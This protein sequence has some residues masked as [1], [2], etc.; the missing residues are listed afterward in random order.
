M[1]S[2][3]Y[4]VQ[5]WEEEVEEDI[6]NEFSDNEFEHGGRESM[7][8]APRASVSSQGSRRDNERA[9]TAINRGTEK[10]FEEQ[11]FKSADVMSRSPQGSPVQ[12]SSLEED[13]VEERV[14]ELSSE[15]KPS[16]RK[17]EI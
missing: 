7:Q 15:K 2:Q 10:V 3:S 12:E 11:E 1:Q 9:G 16:D 8:F 13:I 17:D 5:G 4:K 14:E 6:P